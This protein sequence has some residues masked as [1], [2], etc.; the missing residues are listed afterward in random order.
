[1]YKPV[2]A[3]VNF[4]AMEE[5]ILSF[6]KNNNT[7]KKSVENRQ[8]CEEFVFYD[9]PPFATGL[10]HFGH[11][12]PGTIKDIIPRYQT[13]KGKKVERRF[14][15]DCHGLPVEYEMEKE[16]KISG[17][18]EIEKY[19]V[20]KFN[21][22]C[23][24]IVLR[25]T[26]EWRNVVTRLG[27]WVDFDNEY[28][29][30]DTHYMESIW[31]V[32]S[33][34]WKRKLMYEG[35]YILPYCPR[36]STALSNFELNLGGYQDVHDPAITVRFKL[37]DQKNTYILAWTT[38]PWTLPSNLALALG[39]NITYVKVK[40]RDDFYILAEER[41]SSY[42]K[43]E[44]EYEIVKKYSGRELKGQSYEPLFPYFSS[45]REKGAFVCM[46]ADFV[47]TED[48][49]G[50]VHIAP[51][52]GEDDYNVLR[53][54]DVPTVCPVDEEGRFTAE[55]SDYQGVFVKD[56]DKD[57]IKDLKEQG[58]LVK[59]DAYLH[60]YP[61]CWRCKS[62]L[63]YRAISSWFVNI[64]EIKTKMLASNDQITWMP[65]HLK[66]GRFGKWLDAARDWAISR[67]RYWGNPIPVWRCDSCDEM[68]CLSSRKELEEKSGKKVDDLHKHFVDDLTWACSCG[69]TKKRIPE[70][71]DCWF[72]SGAMPYAQNHY[73]FENKEHF[74]GNFPAD[75]IAEGL[76]QTRGWFYTLTV[77]A[78][79]LFEK[80]AFNNVIVNGLVLAED[81][82]KMSKSE[83]NY[84]DPSKVIQEYGAD[85][86]RLFLMNSAVVRAE[87][88]RFSDEGVKE[89][90]KNVIIPIW[91]AYSFFVTYANIDKITPDSAPGNPS[92]PLDKW[93]LSA[94]ER[95]VESVT[96]D[97]DRYDLQRAIEPILGFIDLLNNWYI[98]RSR[99]RFW[100]S[101]NDADKKEAY[102]TLYSVLMKLIITATPFI[103]FVT[104]EIYQNIKT[105]GMPDSIHLCDYPTA[106]TSRRDL[107]LEKEMETVQ[108]A[109]SMGR[110][111][112][113]LFS[114]KTR[115][116]LSAIH[117]TTRDALEREILGSMQD[118]IVEELN[119]KK[120]IFRENEEDL[121]EY[122]VKPNYKVLGKILGK[123][124][125]QAADSIESLSVKDIIAVVGGNSISISVN[126]QDVSLDTENLVI[127]RTEKEGLKVMNEGSLTVA[128]DPALSDDLIEEGIIRDLVRGIQNQRK[129]KQLHVTDRI[130]LAL[131]GDESM[132]QAVEKY[133]EYI[134]RETLAESWKWEKDGK[135]DSIDCGGGTCL[136]SLEKV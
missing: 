102:E 40:D 117:L 75:F 72:E 133:S 96:C 107:K 79:A 66:A 97:L 19:G 111:L 81:G 87:D 11:F 17:K 45:L 90:L 100:R 127:Q 39:E 4:P 35:Y 67:N 33:E 123:D 22:A 92:N 131:F 120:V 12:V 44:E 114:I 76:D 64:Q 78:T 8:G 41:L 88:L 25:Y 55:V 80:P 42:Y 63:I 24:S 70:V 20:D 62:P 32:V 101:E 112:R 46:N 29:T 106:D 28:R 31:W 108:K 98:R 27:R 56:A 126:G 104:E 57:I 51:G 60:A 18:R 134:S 6:W 54:T 58:K 94:A 73:P 116:P 7:F 136:C 83:R 124:M 91:S 84:T 15:W 135:A 86:L 109:V 53:N 99:R 113:S 49:T 2:D 16:L 110:A 130:R 21:E 128:I 93:I 129:E 125:K 77:L 50:I 34:L 52:F 61:H 23:R 105:S 68:E 13:M 3:K 65:E 122:S 36:C 95:M 69:G 30:M 132:K 119:V 121:V 38:T 5:A 1:M 9:G 103:P 71:L 48:G 74:E 85:A 118:I 47:S 26:K 59:R 37:L 82:K 14:G 89:E 10:P 43:K 115:Q